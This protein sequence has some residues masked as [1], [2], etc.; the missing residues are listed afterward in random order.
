MFLF[1]NSIFW[2]LDN[3]ICWVYW[4]ESKIFTQFHLKSTD[5]A[6]SLQQIISWEL[7]AQ[8][9][10]WET[11]LLLWWS[12]DSTGEPEEKW[13]TQCH[14]RYREKK[15]EDFCEEAQS[16]L[17]LD[18]EWNLA[19]SKGKGRWRGRGGPGRGSKSNRDCHSG[20]KEWGPNLQ[21]RICC[22]TDSHRLDCTGQPFPG[23]S[24]SHSHSRIK[25]HSGAW[26][27]C[28]AV[29]FFLVQSSFP[30]RCRFCSASLI[31]GDLVCPF[32]WCPMGSVCSD[33]MSS[34]FFGPGT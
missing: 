33:A 4:S 25:A 27:S 24:C 12:I 18:E 15:W 3:G 17:V 11:E 7:E 28:V 13:Q 20:E 6:P 9:W 29:P 1:W 14:R 26:N 21:S 5:W 19:R 16:R 2:W 34:L 30:S 22:H 10:T 31:S 8:Y 23:T 32:R